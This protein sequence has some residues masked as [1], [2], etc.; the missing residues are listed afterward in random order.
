MLKLLLLTIFLLLLILLYYKYSTLKYNFMCI[1]YQNKAKIN[2]FVLNFLINTYNANIMLL[3]YLSNDFIKELLLQLRIPY[4][5]IELLR[6][7]L[8]EVNI[9]I[10]KYLSKW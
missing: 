2:S 9:K 5:I 1:R 6:I 4:K 7:F 8:K 10:K 3:E